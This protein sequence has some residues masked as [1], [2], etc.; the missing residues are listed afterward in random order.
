MKRGKKRKRIK[1][2]KIEKR[3][4]EENEEWKENAR[5][6]EESGVYRR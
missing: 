1:N 3:A 6:K 2:L 4:E 5:K